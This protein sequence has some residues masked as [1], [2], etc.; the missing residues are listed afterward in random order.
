M[1]TYLRHKTWSNNLEREYQSVAMSYRAVVDPGS[2]L[3]DS[4]TGLARDRQVLKTGDLVGVGIVPSNS[5]LMNIRILVHEAFAAG[6]TI[7]IYSQADFPGPGAIPLVTDSIVVS[8]QG[9]TIHPLLTNS[10]QRNSDDSAVPST[11]NGG[12]WVGENDG[13][14]IVVELEGT[15]VDDTTPVGDIEILIDYVKFGTNNGAYTG[16]N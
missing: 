13:F 1:A 6:T 9:A 15:D 12:L 14:F 2:D 4:A 11:V 3:R 7:K 10:G 16:G 5:L 8:N